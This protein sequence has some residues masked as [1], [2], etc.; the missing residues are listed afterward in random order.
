MSYYLYTLVVF[1]CSDAIFALGLNLQ[2]GLAGTLNFAYVLF[3]AVGAYVAGCLLTGSPHGSI[4]QSLGET[5]FF[6]GG[7]KAPYL[8]AIVI[9]TL[10]GALLAALVGLVLR[11]SL[12]DDFGALATV[13]IFLVLF[14]IFGAWTPLFNGYNGI[15]EVPNPF[16]LASSWQYPLV[17]V[18]WLLLATL[19][20][21]MVVRSPYGRLMRAIRERPEAVEALGRNVFK[22][23]FVMFVFANAMGAFAGA[24]LVAFVSAWSP[25][26]W[27][28]AETIVVFSA[29]I[30]GGR[31][32]SFGALL[33][34]ALV[35]VGLNQA[36]LFI[37]PVPSHPNLIPSLQWVVTGLV[38]IGFLW[39]RPQGLL[40]ERKLNWRR[41]IAERRSVVPRGKPPS[42]PARSLEQTSV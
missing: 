6:G 37:P 7:F 23:R 3:Y 19:A 30:V 14:T 27:Q 5:Y 17:C 16:G 24:I 10:I 29:V 15:A 13:A 18:G 25:L 34:A 40:P 22:N 11:R 1:F 38:T 39:V 31:G 42:P 26:S 21:L 12:R 2:Y 8:L 33:G 41:I 28:F 4:A 20:T 35:G 32:N 9:A 36:A